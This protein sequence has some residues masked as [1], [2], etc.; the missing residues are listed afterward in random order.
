MAVPDPLTTADYPSDYIRLPFD[1][2]EFDLADGALENLRSTWQD[3]EGNDGDMESVLIET[4]APMAAAAVQKAAEMPPAA[5]IALGTKL[6]GIDYQQGQA[7]MTTVT[8]TFQDNAGGYVVDGGSEFELSGMGFQVV[9]DVEASAGQLTVGGVQVIANDIGVEFNNLTSADWSNVSLPVWVTD[10]STEAPTSGGVDPQDDNDYLDMLS[11]ELQLRGRMVVTLPDYEIVAMDTPGVGRAYAATDSA[12]NVTVTL[13]DPAGEPL[14]ADVKAT[15]AAIYAASRLV[16]VNV[17][18][19]D[20]NYAAID[21]AYEVA[22]LPSFEPTALQQAIDFQLGTTLSPSGWGT[23]YFGQPGSGPLSWI[24]DTVVRL[25][26]IISLI[27][28][29]PG[30]DYVVPNSVLIEGQ[31]NDFQMPGP[32][33][34]PRPGTFTGAVI[35]A[36]AP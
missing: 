7:A 35:P 33:A 11:R 9:N 1:A 3:W 34:L 20:A 22:A 36:V 13:T 24:N 10:L 21:V 15:L 6:Y 8:V 2:D 28:N 16:N 17:T 12:R 29:V 27:G 18:L 5:F 14:G 25:N 32:V 4:L 30:V 23:V 19:A 31:S 26:K